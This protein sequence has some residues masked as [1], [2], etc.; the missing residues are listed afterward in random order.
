MVKKL[1]KSLGKC[2]ALTNSGRRCKNK[3][4]FVIRW[5]RTKKKLCSLHYHD[6]EARLRFKKYG[7]KIH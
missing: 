4:K 1:D 2:E 7:H 5:D 6:D 3:A